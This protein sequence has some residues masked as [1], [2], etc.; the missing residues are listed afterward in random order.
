MIKSNVLLPALFCFVTAA[1]V[2]QPAQQT[3]DWRMYASPVDEFKIE[4]PVP[5]SPTGNQGRNDSRMYSGVIEGARFYIFSDSVKEQRNFKVVKQFAS[6]SGDSLPDAS[7][8]ASKIAFRDRFEYYHNVT[9]IRTKSR[10][11][12]AQTV[13]ASESDLVAERFLK[14]FDI[15]ADFTP[16]EKKSDSDVQFEAQDLPTSVPRARSTGSGSGS[17][18]GSGTSSGGIG[19]GPIQP[20]DSNRPHAPFKILSKPRPAYTDLARF[21]AVQGTVIAKVTFLATGEVGSIELVKKLPF[22]LADQAID[23][24]R[25]IRFTPPFV[26]GKAVNVV[27]VI[28]FSF[29]IY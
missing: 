17:G 2:A 15:R 23:A 24:A 14:S 1:A 19:S 12:I 10:V 26:D 21:Y 8:T 25:R 16:E 6:D 9:V 27:K 11:Y 3:V 13:S 22:G 5:L 20:L 18:S 29:T 4:S 7:E 28:E